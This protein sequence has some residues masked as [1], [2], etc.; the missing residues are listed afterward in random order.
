M[1]A[2]IF[3]ALV[4]IYVAISYVPVSETPK[5]LGKVTG[6]SSRPVLARSRTK[7]PRPSVC[8]RDKGERA[9]N[10]A[11]WANPGAF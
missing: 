2:F 1:D 7:N 8:D 5:R 11:I 10:R 4:V 6:P 3:L 9:S